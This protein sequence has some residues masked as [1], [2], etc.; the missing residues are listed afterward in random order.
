MYNASNVHLMTIGMDSKDKKAQSA[1]EYIMSYGWA[2]L[3]IAIILS[4]FFSLGVFSKQAFLGDACIPSVGFL[5]GQPVLATNGLL[6]VQ[7]GQTA[8]QPYITL[9]GLGCSSSSVEPSLFSAGLEAYPGQTQVI[10]FACPISSNSVGTQFAGTLWIEYTQGPYTGTAEYGTIE[11]K[12]SLPTSVAAP[13]ST[14]TT[15]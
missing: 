2:I 1:M 9:I 10:S 15:I 8:S 7:F 4:A 3:I 6:T 11:M 14:T 5:C 13:T 12:S